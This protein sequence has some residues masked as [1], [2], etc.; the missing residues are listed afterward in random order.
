MLVIPQEN[1]ERT[2]FPKGSETLQKKGLSCS[3]NSFVGVGGKA[4]K[5]VHTPLTPVSSSLQHGREE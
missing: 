4:A 5:D 3:S 1:G 2:L